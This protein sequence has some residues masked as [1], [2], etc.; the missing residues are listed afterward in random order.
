[1]LIGMNGYSRSQ[2]IVHPFPGCT[3]NDLL[4]CEILTLWLFPVK[5]GRSNPDFIR[6]FDSSN[7][8]H[9]PHIS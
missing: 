9:R 4:N 5:Q 3:I 8:L 6:D 1:M 7:C 2:R